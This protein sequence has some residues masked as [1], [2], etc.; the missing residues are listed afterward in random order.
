M[1][2]WVS[3]LMIADSVLEYVPELIRHEYCL[4]NVAPDCNTPNADWTAFTPSRQ[5]THWMQG[6]RKLPEDAER[7]LREYVLSRKKNINSAEELSFLLGYYTHL[8]A[9]A[10]LQG[11]FRDKKRVSEMWRRAEVHPVLREKINEYPIRDWDTF[12]NL[13]DTYHERLMDF[14]TIERDY[15]DS[16]PDSGYLTEFHD[17]DQ[18]PD[19]IEYLPENAVAKKAE[20]MYY[21]PKRDSGM[22]PFLCVTRE[23]YGEFLTRTVRIVSDTLKRDVFSI[24]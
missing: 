8:A 13:Y 7:F 20:L 5:I 10:E 9:D 2:E 14:H 16:H 22:F 12:K 23:E 11:M 18:L 4:G 21:L 15:L 6:K 1:A 3:H 24:L 17:L 19:Y